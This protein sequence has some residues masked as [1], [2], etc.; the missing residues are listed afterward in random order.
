MSLFNPFPPPPVPNL[1]SGVVTPKTRIWLMVSV[2]NVVLAGHPRSLHVACNMP[3]MKSDLADDT[4]I[5]VSSLLMQALPEI[6]HRVGEG[7]W[8]EAIGVGP[9]VCR[10]SPHD[11][12][13]YGTIH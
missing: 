7:L 11:G 6:Y 2:V 8:S 10:V 3:D 13:D 12:Y 9:F 5:Q 1:V 4:K